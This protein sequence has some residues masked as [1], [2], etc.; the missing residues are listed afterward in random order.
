MN[1][2]LSIII[3]TFNRAEFL[4]ACLGSIH[5]CGLTS[6]EVLLVDDGSTDQTQGRFEEQSALP[7]P[8]A[9]Q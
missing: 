9:I 4:D 3:P 7:V 2:E 1:P 5:A 6:R 8:P